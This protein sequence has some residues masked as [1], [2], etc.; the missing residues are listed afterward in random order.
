MG[1]PAARQTDP[2]TGVDTHIVMVPA[3]PG[4]PVPTPLPHPFAGQLADAVS[5]DVLIDGLPAATVGSVAQNLPPHLPTPPGTAFQRPP[6]NRGTV[7]IGSATVLIDGRGAARLG[8]TVQTCNDP[9]DAPVS[10]ITAGSP[11]VVIG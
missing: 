7:T 4:P 2:V 6:T 9:A 1:Q 3:P 5:T 11:T 10:T 8:D